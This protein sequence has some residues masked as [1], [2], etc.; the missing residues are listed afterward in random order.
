MDLILL[1]VIYR[2]LKKFRNLCFLYE[3]REAYVYLITKF[4][5][6]IIIFVFNKNIL[7]IVF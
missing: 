1:N 7:K 5:N 2:V 3:V 4:K 6:I